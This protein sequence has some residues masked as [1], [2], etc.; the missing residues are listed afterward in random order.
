MAAVP[1]NIF[2]MFA[3]LPDI[4]S[5]DFACFD[6]WLPVAEQ[7]DII[8]IGVPHPSP[9]SI[10]SEA[11][12]ASEA[13]KALA[14]P[15]AA[16]EASDTET[17]DQEYCGHHYR[18]SKGKAAPIAKKR[19][20][21]NTAKEYEK[22]KQRVLKNRKSAAK[23]RNKIQTERNHFFNFA[24]CVNA[25]LESNLAVAAKLTAIGKSLDTLSKFIDI[26]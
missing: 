14:T 17:D 5:A 15:E 10:F 6:Q 23:Y 21:F 12:E 4:I 20:D 7:K 16:A 26:N 19:S 11:T 1:E 8:D 22:Y 25:V 24:R 3:T 18:R 2:S 13:A 9:V